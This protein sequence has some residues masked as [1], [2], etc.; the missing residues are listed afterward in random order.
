[1]AYFMWAGDHVLAAETIDELADL[2]TCALGAGDEI[3]GFRAEGGRLLRSA[4]G[5]GVG[6]YRD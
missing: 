2:V 3:T 4:V 5:G 6:L 1:M